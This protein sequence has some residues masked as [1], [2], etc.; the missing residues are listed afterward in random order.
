MTALLIFAGGFV[1]GIIALIAF[2]IWLANSDIM[3]DNPCCGA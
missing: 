1:T 2:L 3:N